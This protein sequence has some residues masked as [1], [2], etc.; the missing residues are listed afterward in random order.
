MGCKKHVYQI[1]IE[2]NAEF[3]SLGELINLEHCAKRPSLKPEFKNILLHSD[4][5]RVFPE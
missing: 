1:F 4:A 3:E 5:Y 2:K